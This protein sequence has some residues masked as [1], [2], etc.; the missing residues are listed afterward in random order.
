MNVD[1]RQLQDMLL[2]HRER[3]VDEWID[4]QRK[5]KA[6][7]NDLIPE[8]RIR[9]QAREFLELLEDAL[10]A[11]GPEPLTG[12]VGDQI[13]HFLKTNSE[14]SVMAGYT[15]VEATSVVL[16]LKQPLR[17]LAREVLSGPVEEVE[18]LIWEIGVLLDNLG[19]FVMET[20]LD[21]KEEVIERQKEEIAELSTPVVQIWEGVVILPLIGTLDSRRTQDMM[22]RLLNMIGQ[23]D[24]GV[25]TMHITG[26]VAVDTLVAQHLLKTVAAARLMGAEC[27]ISGISPA[28]AQTIVQLGVSVGD[29]QTEYKLYD[30]FRRALK[31]SGFSSPRRLE[32]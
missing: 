5:Q 7:R 6:L 1:Q 8:E 2:T 11:G 27:M 16:S 18:S 30:A 12:L 29:V 4:A 22:E 28:I 26:V 10:K 20:F 15:P 31:I 19:L 24:A 3:L 21:K 23:Y 9:I 13:R 14:R 32:D 25:A 17:L